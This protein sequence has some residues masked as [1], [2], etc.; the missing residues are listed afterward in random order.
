MYLD[1]PRQLFAFGLVRYAHPN[2]AQSAVKNMDGQMLGVQGHQNG[3]WHPIRV[4]IV[5][6][7]SIGPNLNPWHQYDRAH[8]AMEMNQLSESSSESS[9]SEEDEDEPG[10]VMF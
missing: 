6:N 10:S 2:E 8:S 4:R 1:N 9:S 5:K 7:L 3:P